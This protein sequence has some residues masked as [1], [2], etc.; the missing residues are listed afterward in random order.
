MGDVCPAHPEFRRSSARTMTQNLDPAALRRSQHGRMPMQKTVRPDGSAEVVLTR[1]DRESS[2]L[3]MQATGHMENL[4][5]VEDILMRVQR[6]LEAV[7]R[8]LP[9]YWKNF[10]QNAIEDSFRAYIVLRSLDALEQ[11]MLDAL[12]AI[13]DTYPR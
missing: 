8:F 11:S 7:Q 3:W 2:D 12:D 9:P 4:A 5:T 10:G 13:Y 6:V 1:E